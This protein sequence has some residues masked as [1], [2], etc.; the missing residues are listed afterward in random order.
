MLQGQN[1]K[2]I[3]ECGN[4][5]VAILKWEKQTSDTKSFV[6][7]PGSL[8]TNI[9]DLTTNRVKA[10]LKITNAQ[11]TDSGVYKCTV[12]VKP[13]KSD[14]KLTNIQVNGRLINIR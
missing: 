3:C 8:V 10:I 7:V 2:V 5:H 4:A 12:S 1:G 13:D 9:K 14:F 11:V 6:P